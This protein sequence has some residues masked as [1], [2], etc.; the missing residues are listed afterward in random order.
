MGRDIYRV[1][2]NILRV[3]EAL[4]F[5][6]GFIASLSIPVGLQ[7]GRRRHGGLSSRLAPRSLRNWGARCRLRRAQRGPPNPSLSPGDPGGRRILAAKLLAGRRVLLERRAARRVR[8]PHTALGHGPAR[9]RAWAA[10]PPTVLADGRAL[11]AGFVLRTGPRTKQDRWEENAGYTPFTLAVTTGASSPQPRIAEAWYIEEV[12]SSAARHG[13]R[14]ERADRGLDLCR[15]HAALAREAGVQAGYCCYWVA[16]EI[17]CD[18]R[19]PGRS[20]TGPG[21]QPRGGKRIDPSRTNSMAR[22]RSRLSGL[23]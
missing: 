23:G 10:G 17:V 3:H 15:G 12:A 20:W 22:T 6:G 16:P 1:S 14:L 5:P 13:R 19:R 2:A 4:T 9:G 18:G 7:Q 21:A 11:L 8:A